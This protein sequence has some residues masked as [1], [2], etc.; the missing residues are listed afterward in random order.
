VLALLLAGCQPPPQPEPPR[1]LQVTEKVAEFP[2]YGEDKDAIRRWMKTKTPV[3]PPE[4]MGGLHVDAYT[5]WTITWRAAHLEGDGGC[6][7]SG[8]TVE[9]TIVEVLPTWAPQEGAP[10]ALVSDWGRYAQAVR[11]HEDGHRDIA[12]EGAQ[13]ALDVLSALGPQPDC[14]ALSAAINRAG[15]ASVAG[16]RARQVA[17]DEETGHGSR[18]GATF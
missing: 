3:P 15:N 11:A 12:L 17:Y 5:S 4:Q 16:T 10:E 6:Y 2:V 7:P 8:L 13:A 1:P 9:A 14:A 18:T